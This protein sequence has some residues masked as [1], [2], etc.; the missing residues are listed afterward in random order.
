[1][2]ENQF[3]TFAEFRS[4]NEDV[5]GVMMRGF[6]DYDRDKPHGILFG[7]NPITCPTKWIPEDRI[8][9]I[10]AISYRYCTSTSGPRRVLY[11]EVRLKL[12]T[13]EE[14]KL[15]ESFLFGL[16]EAGASAQITA[17]KEGR[18]SCS[19]ESSN[20]ISTASDGCGCVNACIGVCNYG[21]H[22]I[23]ICV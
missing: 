15:F 5:P 16:A 18:C 17:R 6:V 9:S 20:T 10:R 1:M 7:M 21:N 13:S 2:D 14:G 3:Q 12:A 23:G 22:C 11:A 8:H 19:G 4:A